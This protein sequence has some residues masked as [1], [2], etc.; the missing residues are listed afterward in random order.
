MQKIR[1]PFQEHDKVVYINERHKLLKKY[2][3]YT[4][5]TTTG[6]WVNLV[7]IRKNNKDMTYFAYDNFI[8][9]SDFRIFK[10]NKIKER[11]CTTSVTK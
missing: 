10:I 9:L 4:V 5:N 11:I 8:S 1:N 6:D 3:I 7:E 2:E